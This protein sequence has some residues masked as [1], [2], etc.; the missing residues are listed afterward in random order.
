MTQNQNDV[1]SQSRKNLTKALVQNSK[2][3]TSDDDQ[4]LNSID[5][6]KVNLDQ[7]SVSNNENKYANDFKIQN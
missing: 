5:H 6:S 2:E 4:K 7:S 3:Q 1:V